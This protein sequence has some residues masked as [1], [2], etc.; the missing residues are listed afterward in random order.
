[1]TALILFEFDYYLIK[2]INPLLIIFFKQNIYKILII[3]WKY[4]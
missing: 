3:L 4:E 1:M 2:L